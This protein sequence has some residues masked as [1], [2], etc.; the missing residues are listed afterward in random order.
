VPLS[1]CS[2]NEVTTGSPATVQIYNALNDGTALYVDRSEEG[3]VY[4]KFN[5]LLTSNT[6]VLGMNVQY[7][8]IP[9]P[10]IAFYS[11]PDTLTKDAPLLKSVFNF[12]PGGIYSLFVYGSKA[13]PG[14][15]IMK[16][17]IPPLKGVDSVTNIRFANFSE[18]QA[19]S[20]NLKDQPS[21]SFISEVSL[22]TASAFIELSANNA[23]AKYDFEIR[24][25][26]TGEL[27]ASFTADKVNDHTNNNG[28]NLWYNKSNTLVFVGKKGETGLLLPRVIKM[29][30]R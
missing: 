11:A 29:S 15:T 25:Q 2:K 27:L 3:P 4:F 30:H 28:S 23:V 19:I 6:Y 21:G 20:I 5:R 14:Y 1:A 12:D 26:I 10:T 9:N 24:D 13:T 16:D 18:D 17:I 7:F 8:D 22:G